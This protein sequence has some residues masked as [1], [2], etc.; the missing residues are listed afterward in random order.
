MRAAEDIAVTCRPALLAAP[1]AAVPFGISEA[2]YLLRDF[3]ERGS[4]ASDQNC[5]IYGQ[6]TS[7]FGA[8]SAELPRKT[9]TSANQSADLPQETLTCAK[10]SAEIAEKTSS[11]GKQ[12]AELRPKTLTS[13]KQTAD[14]RQKTSSFIGKIRFCRPRTAA[15]DPASKDSRLVYTQNACFESALA[16]NSTVALGEQDARSRGGARTGKATAI[17]PG[18]SATRRSS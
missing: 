6:R 17:S 14:L 8:K 1:A 13:A 7:S 4:C 10:Q 12:S 9:L 18:T 5:R 2:S 11:T 3:R 15:F 16:D